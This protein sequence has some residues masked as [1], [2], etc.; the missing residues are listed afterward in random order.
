MRQMRLFDS[1]K[2]MYLRQHHAALFQKEGRILA[3]RGIECGEGWFPLIDGLCAVLGPA[4]ELSQIKE[5]FGTLHVYAKSCRETD[6][7]ALALA[8]R[9]SA[10]VCEETGSPGLFVKMGGLVCSR[11]PSLL[12]RADFVRM[13]MAQKAIA[14][15]GTMSR[16]AAL[17]GDHPQMRINIPPG[18]SDLVACLIG[19]LLCENVPET[20]YVEPAEAVVAIE[21]TINGLKIDV[22]GL[23][24]HHRGAIALAQALAVRI[25]P[26]SGKLMPLPFLRNA[27]LIDR[28]EG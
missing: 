16:H 9:F 23:N 27:G 13:N 5:K 7:G 19:A 24:D 25:D 11:S 6:R 17:M 22:R 1:E 15:L 14:E 4:V 10:F 2:E 3:D 28:L 18:W 26:T 12:N 21:A 8:G 20:Y